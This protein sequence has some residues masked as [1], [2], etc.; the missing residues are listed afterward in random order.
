MKNK[1]TFF[2][3]IFP[4]A[5]IAVLLIIFSVL[6]SIYRTGYLNEIKL[7]E[8]NTYR[9]R[10]SYYD[11]VFRNSDIYDVYLDTKNTINDNSFIKNI[12]M[13]KKGSPFGTL[14]TNKAIDINKKI[15]NIK[16]TLKI[17]NIIYFYAFIIYILIFICLYFFKNIKNVF[18]IFINFIKINKKISMPVLVISFVFIILLLALIILGSI[19]RTGYLNEIK[20]IENNTY[21]FRI[22]YYDKVFR[23]SDIYDVYLD[24]KKTINDNNFIKDIKMNKKGSPFGTLITDKAIDTE[25]ID[26]IKYT[27][28][29]KEII[30]LYA[31]IIY[32]F[33]IFLFYGIWIVKEN[34]LVLVSASLLIIIQIFIYFSLY[35]YFRLI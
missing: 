23:N 30:Y 31:L 22:S 15:D 4:L 14:T 1:K 3:C 21:H 29:I 20:L 16:Y 24:T 28:K 8:N 11:K 17:K 19:A 34:K 10:I 13:D 9:F 33:S 26:N 27:L 7:I 12:K 25:K 5:F 32:L 18:K 2:I 6:G 35:N